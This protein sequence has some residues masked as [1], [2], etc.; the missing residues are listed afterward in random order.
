MHLKSFHKDE[1]SNILGLDAISAFYKSVIISDN[2][3][4]SLF[5]Y[6]TKLVGFMIYFKDYSKFKSGIKI[7]YLLIPSRIIKLI[8]NFFKLINHLIVI[9]HQKKIPKNIYKN[10]LGSIAIQ[11][12]RSI[13]LEVFKTLV[14]HYEEIVHKYYK[15]NCWASCRIDNQVASLILKKCGLTIKGEYGWNP[16]ILFYV[17][18]HSKN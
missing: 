10:Y 11:A 4:I 3:N 2:A 15:D 9:Y 13:R 16:K 1:L 6:K 5:F 18:K 7:N 17:T 8:K 12:N 14:S